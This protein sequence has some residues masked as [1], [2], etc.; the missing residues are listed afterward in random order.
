MIL[1][2]LSNR[3]LVGATVSGGTGF[4]SYLEVLNPMLTFASLCIGICVGLVTL[5]LQIRKFRI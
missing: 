4:V 5:W 1:D 2:T 3:P